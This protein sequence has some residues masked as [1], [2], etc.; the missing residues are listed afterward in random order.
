MYIYMRK[1]AM[2]ILY[3]DNMTQNS[4]T[5]N[6]TIPESKNIFFQNFS[7]NTFNTFF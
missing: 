3:S 7:I 6:L 1:I 5:I 4:I 2:K